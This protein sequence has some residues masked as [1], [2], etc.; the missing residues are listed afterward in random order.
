MLDTNAD[1]DVW[2]NE[3]MHRLKIAVFHPPPE[4]Y[5]QMK[6]LCCPAGTCT[7]LKHKLSKRLVSLDII[8]LQLSSIMCY[9][10]SALL[11]AVELTPAD[12]KTFWPCLNQV[13]VQ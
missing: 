3:E 8:S 1:Q 9:C 10:I 5:E 6:K 12:Q 11:M 4:Y 13:K 2:I 7:I